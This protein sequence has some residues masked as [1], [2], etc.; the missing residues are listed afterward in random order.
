M[1][2]SHFLVHEKK[3]ALTI[4]QDPLVHDIRGGK[5]VKM[6]IEQEVNPL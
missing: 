4:G 3:E 2:T 5:V 1:L 6:R